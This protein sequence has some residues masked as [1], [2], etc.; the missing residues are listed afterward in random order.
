MSFTARKSAAWLLAMGVFAFS[1]SALATNGYFTHG[2]G[3]QSKGMAGTGVGS[4]ADMGSI[5]TASNPALGV[6]VDDRWEA[7]LSIFSPRRS[8]E[9]GPTNQP[10][11]GALIDLGPLN[12]GLGACAIDNQAACMPSHSIT[13]GKIDSSSEYFPIPFF[14]KNWSLEGDANITAVFYGRG[15][16]NTDWDDPNSSATSYFCGADPL[17]G[18]PLNGTGPYCAELTSTTG[19]GTAGVNLMQAF[20]AVNYSNKVNN[21]FS[22]GAGPVFAVQ[23]FEA[24][25]IQTFAPITE[26]F[27]ENPTQSPTNLSNNDADT[28]V[29]F[30]F[31]AGLWWG[32]TDTVS[33]GLAYQSRMYMSEFDDYA[34][35]FAEDGDFDIPSSIKLGLSFVAS[36]QL[37]VNFD[38]EH[39]AFGEVDSIA[40]PMV[41]ML[42][43]DSP[44][45]PPAFPFGGSEREYCL[46]GDNGPG[47]GWQDMTTYKLGFEWTQN[48]TN[49]WR[50]GYSYGEQPI[51]GADVLFNILAPGVM[52]QHI[53]FGLTRQM[54]NGSELSFSFMYAPENSVTGPSF[55]DPGPDFQSPQLIELTMS[56]LEFEVAYSF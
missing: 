26:S 38:I 32:I 47:F 31:A 24:K 4:N 51:Q 7:G 6:F 10:F 18:A 13:P 14:A 41:N 15:G 40:N 9:A 34:D 42:R 28:S 29:G 17:T 27:A 2:V 5:M 43:C 19:D 52:E 56:Q 46:G 33:L 36:E 16:M 20:L 35:L 23:M 30:G 3:T 25:G 12:P 50:F 53:T 54:G 49:T 1:G 11:P 44:A 55:F 22:W 45:L 37:R 21:N 39:T 48:E 8:Y